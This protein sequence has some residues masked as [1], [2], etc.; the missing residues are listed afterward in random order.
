M[1]E[2]DVL[3]DVSWSNLRI[4]AFPGMAWSR[5]AG[6]VLR[7]MRS[8]AL[9]ARRALA[10]IDVALE[11]QPHLKAIPWYQL[12]HGKRIVRWLLSRP[13]RGQTLTSVMAT[14]RDERG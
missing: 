12:S 6:D 14:L 10:A 4:S 13:P 1:S 8:R 11:Q 7:Y 5:T 9:P 2:R 3:T